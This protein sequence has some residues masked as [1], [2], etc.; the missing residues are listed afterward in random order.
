MLEE[1]HALV[2][3]PAAELGLARCRIRPHGSGTRPLHCGIEP[4]RHRIGRSTAELNCAT[5]NLGASKAEEARR[6]RPARLGSRPRKQRGAP[7][8][9]RTRLLQTS[10]HARPPWK[11][12]LVHNRGRGDLA[13]P[14]PPTPHTRRYWSAGRV[15]AGCARGTRKDSE[16]EGSRNIARRWGWIPSLDSEGRF[17]IDCWNPFLPQFCKF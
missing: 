9:R 17:W 3:E 7:P 13:L 1:Q 2:A 12:S 16:R 8:P 6:P 4:H 14:P 10:R 15:R 5:A 11:A